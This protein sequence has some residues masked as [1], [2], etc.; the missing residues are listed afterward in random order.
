MILKRSDVQWL[1][2]RHSLLSAEMKASTI[3][4]TLSISSYYDRETNKL[5]SGDGLSIGRN[6][7]FIADRFLI[8]IHLDDVDSN[9][10]PKVYEVGFRHRVIAKRNAIPEADLHF[11]PQGYACL[12]LSHRMEPSVTLRYFIVGLV[13]P[14]F[15]RLSY[16]DHYGIAAARDDL[17]PEYSHGDRG[18]QEHRELSQ[19]DEWRAVLEESLLHY[20]ER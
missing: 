20:Q 19:S 11:Y 14:F 1:W 4:G 15:Y 3:R 10:W 18:H 2:K 7:T 6:E 9:G 5:I 8:E 12:G 16:V 13:E 17:W